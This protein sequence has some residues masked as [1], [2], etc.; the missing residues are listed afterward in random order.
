MSSSRQE[1]DHSIR[2]GSEKQAPTLSDSDSDD[3][4]LIAASPFFYDQNREIM[5]VTSANGSSV[6]IPMTRENMTCFVKSSAQVIK[7]ND[8]IPAVKEQQNQ[9]GFTAVDIA[10]YNAAEDELANQTLAA[11]FLDELVPDEKGH[12]KN[13]AEKKAAIIHSMYKFTN[14]RFQSKQQLHVSDQL[15]CDKATQRNLETLS[16]FGVGTSRKSVQKLLFVDHGDD[17]ALLYERLLAEGAYGTKFIGCGHDNLQW[18]RG[19]K[20][21]HSVTAF[22]MMLDEGGDDYLCL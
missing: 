2:E 22:V 19:G 12:R 14:Q 11:S 3:D 9:R 20:Y 13:N 8:I 15:R 18:G 21:S 1:D 17:Y 7:T 10:L 5:V 16:K 4:N 6:E